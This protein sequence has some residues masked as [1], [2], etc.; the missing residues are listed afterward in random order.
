MDKEKLMNLAIEE[1]KKSK[2][3][4]YGCLIVKDNEIICKAHNTVENDK[5][6]TA[7]AE[8]NAIKEAS[9]KLDT[10]DLKGC[11]LISS[12]EPCPM[13]FSAA[14][15]ANIDKIIYGCNISDIMNK[16]DPQIPINSEEINKKSG[17]EI[18]IEGGIL[19]D[20]CIEL[21]RD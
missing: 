2:N 18:I 7:H 17:K 5:D 11:T 10:Y 21:I 4:H 8:I 19:K 12:C 15:W 14:W 16:G 9:K 6:P 3:Y 1:A 13:C 20:K